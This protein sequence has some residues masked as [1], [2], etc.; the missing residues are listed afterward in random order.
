MTRTV[1]EPKYAVDQTLSVHST[2]WPAAEGTVTKIQ[3]SSCADYGYRYFLKLKTPTGTDV[4]YFY[5]PELEP[6][7]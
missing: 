3:P 5:E 7:P 6:A 1:S 2:E 4:R